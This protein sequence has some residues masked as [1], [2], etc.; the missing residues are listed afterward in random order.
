MLYSVTKNHAFTDG[1]KRIASTVFLSYL[2]MNNLLYTGDGKKRIE[3]N[4]MCAL[5]LLVAKS[6]KEEK[7]VIESVI[8]NLINMD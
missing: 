3:E 6:G 2:D 8:T 4:T 1:N 5:T 7:E